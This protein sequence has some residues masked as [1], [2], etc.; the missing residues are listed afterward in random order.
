M[1]YDHDALRQELQ[2]AQLR[3]SELSTALEGVREERDRLRDKLRAAN[4]RIDRLYLH[5]QQGVEL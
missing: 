3:I 2:E 4:I 5:L 1:T